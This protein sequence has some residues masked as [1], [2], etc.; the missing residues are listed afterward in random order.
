MANPYIL[1]GI[2]PGESMGIPDAPQIMRRQ[3]LAQKLLEQS[4]EAPQSQMVSGRYVAPSW[5]QYLAQ[6][7][8]GVQ[9]QGQLSDI[10][11]QL[12]Q[13]NEQKRQAIANVLSGQQPQQVTE[14]KQ[15]K[16]LPAY[17]PSQMDRFG[18]PM[19]PREMQTRDVTMQRMESPEEAQNRQRANLYQAISTYGNDPALQLA[20]GDLNYGR[21]RADTRADLTE[22]R[23]YQEGRDA[24]KRQQALEDVGNQQE[25]QRIMMK[26][27][28]G[29]QTTQQE[30]Q[31][32][33][34]YKMLGAQQAFQ[35]QQ[36]KANQDFQAGQNDLNRQATLNAEARKNAVF[37]NPQQMENA[38]ITAQQALDQASKVFNH[39]G[40]IAGTGATSFISSVPGTSAK[41]F[42]ANLETFKAQTFLPMVQAL[43][44]LGALSNAE[45]DKLNA[46][47]GALDPAMPTSEFNQSLKEITRT[48][49]NKAK[50]N[51]LNVNLP[52]FA[53]EKSQKD[54]NFPSLNINDDAI[55]QELKNRGLM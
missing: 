9:A 35:A 5:T 13:Y 11:K 40:K 29:F 25:F 51:G 7:V 44:G 1:Q 31:F 32:A 15:E 20:L 8:R 14:T 55:T 43:K 36:N 3:Q 53:I 18:S 37:Q 46:A 4:Q 45:G 26:E 28:Q 42:S 30:K 48:L 2:M 39:P 10:D 49:Y 24:L 50:A 33:Q 27:Q 6:A 23:S 52:D 21:Q 47:V 34:Q 16:Y 22:G 41:G 12:K 38:R 54:K 19:Q 17:E